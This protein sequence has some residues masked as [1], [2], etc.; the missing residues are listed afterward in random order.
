MKT[1]LVARSS[2][3]SK[4]LTQVQPGP[5]GF[6]A[7]GTHFVGPLGRTT[8]TTFATLRVDRLTARE[9]ERFN[10]TRK[11]S[12]RRVARAQRGRR[13]RSICTRRA[14]ASVERVTLAVEG[15]R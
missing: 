5:L 14:A 3:S 4:D 13:S 6:R 2:R 11:R 8:G 10:L 1:V 7:A 9:T 15:M 12:S